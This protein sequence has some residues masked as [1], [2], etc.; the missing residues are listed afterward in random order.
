VYAVHMCMIWSRLSS[1]H[2]MLGTICMQGNPV[3]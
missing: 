2:Y 3:L 1:S